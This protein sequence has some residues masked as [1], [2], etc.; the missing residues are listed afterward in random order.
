MSATC[1]LLLPPRIRRALTHHIHPLQVGTSSFT[2][3]AGV[4]DIS[5]L[6]VAGGWVEG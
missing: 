4:T 1:D 2:V 6:I 3:P 5:L